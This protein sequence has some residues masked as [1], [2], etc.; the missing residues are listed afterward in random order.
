LQEGTTDTTIEFNTFDATG[1]SGEH[2]ADSFIDLKGQRS[3]VRYNTFHRNG[4]A[5]LTKGVAIVNRQIE[6]F[7]SF[8][9]VIHN[10]K[11]FL[12]GVSSILMVNAAAGT[13]DIWAWDNE[14]DSGGTYSS[15]VQTECCPP[16]YTPPIG[17]PAP[18]E[19]EAT[20]RETSIEIGWNQVSGALFYFVEVK[21]LGDSTP[22]AVYSADINSFDISYLDPDTHYIVRLQTV[23]SYTES[24]WSTEE[25]I[26]TLPSSSYCDDSLSFRFEDDGLERSCGYIRY[27]RQDLVP[28]LCVPG[29]P[30]NEYCVESCGHCSDDCNEDPTAPV[31][32]NDFYGTKSCKWVAASHYRVAEFCNT[33]FPSVWQSCAETCENCGAPSS[34][35][36][37]SPTLNPTLSPA[38]NP[39]VAP[40]ES[41]PLSSSVTPSV[42]PTD[43]PTDSSFDSSSAYPSRTPWGITWWRNMALSLSSLE[44]S[45]HA[46]SYPAQSLTTA[47]WLLSMFLI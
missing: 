27:Y 23:C 38:G 8:E 4:A 36:T 40:T 12:D 21:E 32:I 1:L 19:T 33:D 37:E 45:S 35:P 25:S 39:T 42:T 20:T 13:R 41:P 2:N 15:I 7:S 26:W 14:N 10:N 43:K 29:N 6:E 9:H 31:Y 18:K 5:A 28:I 34:G 11:F 3:H 30:V 44:P 24:S 16:W 47:L 46:F 22:L 17:C